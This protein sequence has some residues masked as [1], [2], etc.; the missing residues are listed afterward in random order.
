MISVKFT[1]AGWEKNFVDE[2]GLHL[3]GFEIFQP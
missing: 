2:R 3:Y 1:R